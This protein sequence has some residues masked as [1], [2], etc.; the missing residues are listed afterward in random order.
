MK[1]YIDFDDVLCETAK[2]FTV[3]AKDLFGIVVPYE[4]VHFFNLQKSFNLNDEQY[5]KLMAAG[6]LPENLLA[7]EETPGASATI[8]KW[9][10][11]LNSK[12]KVGDISITTSAPVLG[13]CPNCGKSIIKMKWR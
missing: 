6:H 4:Q 5:D 2:Y 13:V 11:E 12:V 7:Y 8:N 1:V 9:I 3:L 10:D